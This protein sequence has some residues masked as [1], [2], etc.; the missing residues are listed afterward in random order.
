MKQTYLELGKD[1][2]VVTRQAGA[3]IQATKSQNI[4]IQK[5]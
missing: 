5:A 3:S 2:L 4:Q 1:S